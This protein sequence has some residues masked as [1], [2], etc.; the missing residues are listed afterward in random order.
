MPRK[1]AAADNV[2][3]MARTAMITTTVG[4]LFGLTGD[5]EHAAINFPDND[6]PYIPALDQHYQFKEDDVKTA[7]LWTGG[8]AGIALLLDGPTGCGKS[9]LV[10]QY[11][12]RI[13]KPI[14]R[15][16]C[17]ARMDFSELVGRTIIK[18]DGS[19][20]FVDGPLIQA[21]QTGSTFLLDEINF[22][23]AGMVGAM[24][25][26][27]D[28][29]PLFVPEKDQ[30]IVPHPSFRIAAT[31]NSV[32]S[33]SK[34]QVYR[35]TNRMNLALL[36]RFLGVKCNFLDPIEEVKLLHNVAPEIP[37]SVLQKMVEI[38]N[39]VRKSFANDDLTT[40][41]GTRVLKRWALILNRRASKFG[42]DPYPELLSALKLVLTNLADDES[43]FAIEGLLERSTK[44]MKI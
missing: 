40:T 24:N 27:L 9:S 34:S 1:N 8:E 31:G 5:A 38:A 15:L 6:H 2:V 43:A 17:H 41:M 36:Q 3:P 35:G 18:S 10:E 14:Y 26:I 30:L 20:A 28:R 4:E 23:P 29:A 7:I 13:K 12:N 25:T 33:D 37:G 21:M 42:K 39:D 19:T 11:C 44:G 22:L 16:A 32:A